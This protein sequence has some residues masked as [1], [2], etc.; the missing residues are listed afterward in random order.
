M[1]ISNYVNVLLNQD[2]VALLRKVLHYVPR[3]WAMIETARWTTRDLSQVFGRKSE[4]EQ[5]REYVMH[6]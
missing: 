6:F 4:A 1:Y 2:A 5:L 3:R